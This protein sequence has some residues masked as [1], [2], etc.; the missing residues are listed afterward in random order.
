MI[1]YGA[2][3]VNSRCVHLSVSSAL[4]A[5]VPQLVS[6]EPDIEPE[7][8]KKI[9]TDNVQKLPPQLLTENGFRYM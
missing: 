9:F 8:V 4:P 1:N 5:H 7:T 6:D 2:Q 3:S